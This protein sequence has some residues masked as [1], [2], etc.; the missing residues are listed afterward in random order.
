M[1]RGV[2]ASEDETRTKDSVYRKQSVSNLTGIDAIEA[3]DRLKTFALEKPREYAA[4]RSKV[5]LSVV[6]EMVEKNAETLWDFLGDGKLPD[7]ERIKIGGKSWNAGLPDSDVAASVNGFSKSVKEAF[8]ELMKDVMP[9]DY[10]TLA[11]M[12][13][14]HNAR[15]EGALRV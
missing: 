5:Y 2:N 1:P 10:T 12:K 11:Q 4:E 7:G 9:D 3:R 14:I 8:E 15:V 13:S 6:R